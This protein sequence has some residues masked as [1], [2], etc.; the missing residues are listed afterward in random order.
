MSNGKRRLTRTL[1]ALT[2]GAALAAVPATAAHAGE[3]SASRWSGCTQAISTRN[4]GGTGL[5]NIHYNAYR[6]TTRKYVINFAYSW[7]DNFWVCL[8]DYQVSP[9]RTTVTQEF[10]FDGTSLSCSDGFSISY[11]PGFSFSHSCTAT[12]S[13]LTVKFSN[14]C[15]WAYDC[16]V[17]LGYFE[18]LADYSGYFYNYVNAETIVTVMNSNG[19]PFTWATGY[20]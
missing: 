17:D 12:G 11:P 19:Y 8:G 18:V 5:A 3:W 7:A 20:V 13:T 1:L 6:S 14:T 16:H 4:G 15:A 9:Y 10:R 2:M